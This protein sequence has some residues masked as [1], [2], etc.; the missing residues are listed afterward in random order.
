MSWSGQAPAIRHTT[1]SASGPA[2]AVVAIIAGW[3]TAAF[4]GSYVDA[5]ALLAA[6]PVEF[7]FVAK[8]ELLATP[9]LGTV[10]RKV[11]HLTVERADPS[12]SAADAAR[13][14]AALGGGT[15]LLVFPEGTLRRAAGLLPFRLGAFKAAVEAGRPVVPVTIR[16]TRE[17]LPADLAPPAGPDH[18][19]RWLSDPAGGDRLAGNG[20]PPG[21]DSGRDHPL[22][23]WERRPMNA[24]SSIRSRVRDGSASRA[25]P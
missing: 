9:V 3:L 2:F 4:I 6:I 11:G 23:R 5:V 19:H 17:I 20:P 15:S 8:R 16:G 1:P 21:P 13:V 24:V 7:R 14:G 10:I 18:G 25:R 12:Q 22:S